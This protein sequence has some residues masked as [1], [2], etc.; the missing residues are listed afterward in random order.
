MNKYRIPPSELRLISTREYSGTSYKAFVDR[1][2]APR[3]NRWEKLTVHGGRATL[4]HLGP[5]RI[6]TILL[7]EGDEIWVKPGERWG[8]KQ[9]DENAKFVVAPHAEDNA[10][11]SEP[12]TFRNNWLYDFQHYKASDESALYEIL[13]S[14]D[15]GTRLGV[16]G[17]FDWRPAIAH[18]REHGRADITWHL[19]TSSSN[20][21]FVAIAGCV[22][23]EASITDYLGRD[24]VF[25][26]AAFSIALKNK[27]AINWYYFK[28]MLIRHIRIEEGVLFPLFVKQNSNDAM[29]SG[30][31]REHR[32][33]KQCL[34][35]GMTPVSTRRLWRLLEAHD[36]KEELI[37][38]PDIASIDETQKTDYI[39][40]ILTYC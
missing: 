34:D 38:Y 29:V 21:K 33:I 14:M 4:E 6:E 12:H 1:W 40:K 11:S 7:E 30:L 8:I 13:D 2:H 32:Y 25:M 24:H 35:E 26:E 15:T 37:V 10:S 28:S 20:N 27:D 39:T 9:V 5:S 22:D 3:L 19:M 18:I 36:E 17:R 31:L 16:Q 23:G